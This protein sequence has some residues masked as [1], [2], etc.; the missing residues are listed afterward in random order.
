MSNKVFI[1]LE[2]IRDFDVTKPLTKAGLLVE[3]EARK[4]CPVDTGN[5]RS[6]IKSEVNGNTAT[7]G[8]NVEYAP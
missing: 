5:L 4:N 6:S 7:I 3:R 8:T 2:S 1:K